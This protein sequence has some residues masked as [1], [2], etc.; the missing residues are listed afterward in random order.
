MEHV[1]LQDPVSEVYSE[2]YELMMKSNP[3]ELN[4]KLFFLEE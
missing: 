3:K 4:D 2:V 1:D